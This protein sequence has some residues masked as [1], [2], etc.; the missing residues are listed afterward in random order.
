MI[1]PTNRRK[2]DALIGR[3]DERLIG[4]SKSFDDHQEDDRDKF[5]VAFKHMS[6]GF[7]KMDDRFDKIDIKLGTLWDQ[8]NSNKGAFGASRLFAGFAWAV[9]VLV[10][11]HFIT[12]A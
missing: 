7:D 12:R 10:A 9:V 2:D 6:D 8:S 1:Q 3:I 4:L 5:E 11:N